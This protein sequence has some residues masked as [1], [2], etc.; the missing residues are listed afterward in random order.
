[1]FE[2]HEVDQARND[3]E[4]AGKH[5]DVRV[6][7]STSREHEN[8]ERGAGYRSC[9]YEPDPRRPPQSGMEMRLATRTASWNARGQ[10]QLE[11]S[12]SSA[13]GRE[14]ADPDDDEALG[15]SKADSGVSQLVREH[16]QLDADVEGQECKTD[17]QRIG[18]AQPVN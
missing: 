11:T 14:I 8:R 4:R 13:P 3:I 6:R 17:P 1:M 2:W 5:E 10:F 7:R 9:E 12:N 18:D 15:S 16:G